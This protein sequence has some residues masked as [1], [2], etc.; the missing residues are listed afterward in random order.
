M[1]AAGALTWLHAARAPRRLR[2]R[3]SAGA[4]ASP[5]LR[6]RALGSI[7]QI[8]ALGLG[9]MALLM[10]TLIRTDLLRSVAAR[11]CRPT[12]RTASSSTSSPT[13][14]SRCARSSPR[15]A[16]PS[17]SLYPDGARPARADQ[18]ARRV[19]RRDY[20]DERARRLVEREFNLSWA[21]RC[22]RQ[23]GRGRALVGAGEAR[24][25]RSSRSRTGIAETL[26]MKL[27]DPLTFDVGGHAGR[28]R[29]VTS[30]RKVDWDS[31][32]VELLRDRAA[33]AARRL[34]RDLRDELP[35]A[36]RA[37]R[38][39]DALVQRVSQH[40]ADRRRRRCSRRCRG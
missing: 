38:V 26:G 10:L 33:R 8:V 15:T 37:S 28:A 35:P 34:S 18:R 12:R 2:G 23:P 27:G 20:A 4:T 1:L 31:F 7:V 30:L 32:N 11:A 17:R 14:S 13:R 19:V 24:R 9:M 16:S 25:R 36:A 3:A 22:G 5:N 40:R 6:R 21:A 29:R 39:P